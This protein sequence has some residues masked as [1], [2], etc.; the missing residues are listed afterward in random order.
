MSPRSQFDQPILGFG[1]AGYSPLGPS[2]IVYTK[3]A[4]LFAFAPPDSGKTESLVLPNIIR[5]LCS[6]IVIDVQGGQ[7]TKKCALY[8]QN[9]LGHE[10]W[11]DDPIRIIPLE[12]MPTLPNGKPAYA[13]VNAIG[14]I[15]RSDSPAITAK[16]MAESGMKVS[17]NDPHWSEGAQGTFAGVAVYIAKHPDLPQESKTMETV[18]EILTTE[19]LFKMAIREMRNSDEIYVRDIANGYT[20]L[21]KDDREMKGIRSNLRTQLGAV[22][23]DRGIIKSLTSDT[24]DYRA[25]NRRPITVFRVLPGH[26]ST[27]LMPYIKM[28]TTLIL[29]ELEQSGIRPFDAPQAPT[30]LSFDEFN[31]AG[32]FIPFIDALARGRNYGLQA[33]CLAQSYGQLAETYGRDGLASLMGNMGIVQTFGGTSDELTAN[34]ISRLSGEATIIAPSVTFSHGGQEGNSE[35]FGFT[36][37]RIYT[38]DEVMRLPLPKQL[39]SYTGVGM[40]EGNLFQYGMKDFPD[41]LYFMDL[42]KR[43]IDP[44]EAG[45]R[46]R[47]YQAILNKNFNEHVAKMYADQMKPAPQVERKKPPINIGRMLNKGLAH[48]FGDDT[49]F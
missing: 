17:G 3:R 34:E 19:K 13:S 14:A 32:K 4:H 6:K 8:C 33:H 24:V 48:L 38:P 7:I 27:A 16:A 44:A 1:P 9:V 31:S 45:Q 49:D 37:R 28:S 20:G 40:A 36:K 22:L 42:I 46:T 11:V 35:S 29:S 30:L 21:S 12:L 41:Y 10:T 18:W 2:T 15:G 25:L 5:R 26:L 47:A 23:S 43:G 39:I